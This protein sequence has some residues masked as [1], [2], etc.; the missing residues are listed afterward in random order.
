MWRVVQHLCQGKSASVAVWTNYLYALAV[1][2]NGLWRKT[3]NAKVDLFANLASHTGSYTL[4]TETG[5]SLGQDTLQKIGLRQY[6]TT[7]EKFF[8]D[9]GLV[10]T[11]TA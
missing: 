2:L 8:P 1:V 10:V 4:Q 7:A 9:I 5:V 11:K 3:S 6:E